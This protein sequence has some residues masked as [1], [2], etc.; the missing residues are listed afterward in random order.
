[1]FKFENL[2]NEQK[3]EFMSH[4]RDEYKKI[5]SN[6]DSVV[7]LEQYKAMRM[8]SYEDKVLEPFLSDEAFVYKMEICI[9]NAQDLPTYKLARHYDEYLS[10]DGVRE[11]MKRFKKV[12]NIVDDVEIL[13]FPPMGD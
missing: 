6:K 5:I 3:I 8:N 10:T 4:V 1:M 12:K 7:S 11:L 9:K 2:K 13:V